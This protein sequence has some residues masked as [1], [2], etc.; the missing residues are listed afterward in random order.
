MKTLISFIFLLLFFTNSYTQNFYPIER[1]KSRFEAK[2][3][4]NRVKQKSKF[5]YNNSQKLLEEQIVYNEIGKTVLIKNNKKSYTSITE[6]K[7]DKFGMLSSEK[8][9]ALGSNFLK[10]LSIQ[11]PENNGFLVPP[12]S[13]GAEINIT[14]KYNKKYQLINKEIIVS[15]FGESSSEITGTEK[16]HLI[17]EYDVEGNFIAIYD[18][19]KD[20]KI[21]LKERITKKDTVQYNF[22]DSEGKLVAEE[23][24]DVSNKVYL[25]KKYLLANN[26]NEPSSIYIKHFK[27]D[28]RLLKEEK[29]IKDV[30]NENYMNR[31][32]YLMYDSELDLSDIVEMDANNQVIERI[33]N[34]YN[35]KGLLIEETILSPADVVKKRIEYV[36]EYY[37]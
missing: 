34:N 26:L 27:K 8:T 32:V 24:Y 28:Y 19:K 1:N 15:Y 3:R 37:E 16:Y 10:A 18:L 22:L 36:Y 33:R 9:K 6:Y 12:K 2:M 35:N 17:N 25:Q 4:S 7:Y 31:N 11:F 5:V 13:N 23:I 29:F 14:Y 21:K 30:N 20:K